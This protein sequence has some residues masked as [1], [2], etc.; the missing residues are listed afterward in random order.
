MEMPR[1]KSPLRVAGLAAVTLLLAFAFVALF[2][3]AMAIVLLLAFGRGDFGDDLGYGGEACPASENE[4][5]R[6]ATSEPLATVQGL[7]AGGR[8]S[9]EVD[10]SGNS[11]IACAVPLNRVDVVSALLDAGADPNARSR[12]GEHVLADAARFCR[13]E[14]AAALLD[15]GADPDAADRH[16]VPA[17]VQ[18]I[19]LGDTATAE[20]LVE[21]GADVTHLQHDRANYQFDAERGAVCPT[22]DFEADDLLIGLLDRDVEPGDHPEPRCAARRP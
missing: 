14:M 22:P 15:A 18:A 13:T 1:R 20:V 12:D 16:G 8:D 2:L 17:L 11:A 10:S 5:V 19:D 3:G 9:N 6:A 4:L 21:A 7:L